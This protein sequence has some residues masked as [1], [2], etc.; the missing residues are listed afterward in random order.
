MHPCS[1]TLGLVAQA[2]FG[3]L[4]FL[5][6]FFPLRVPDGRVATLAD[7]PSQVGDVQLPVEEEAHG[8]VVGRLVL[9]VVDA[10]RWD[11]VA[12][13]AGATSMPYV[14]S[15]LGRGDSCLLQARAD[16][17]TVTMPRIKALTTGSVPGFVDVVLNLG[18]PEVG[19]DSLVG[20]AVAH[21]LKV[22]FYGDDT[23]LK[24]F[25]RG[26]ARSEGTSSFFVSDYTEVDDNVT[27]HLAAEL[28]APDWDLMV[29]HYLGLDHIGHLEGP[30][31]PLVAP[32]LREM[33]AVARQ[34]HSRLRQW[35]ESTNR[36]A[37]VVICGDHG[38]KDS[39]SHGG[40]S[41]AE[42][43][44][45]IVTLG[46]GC[47]GSR[48]AEPVGQIDLAPTLSV[49]LGLPIPAGSL[50]KLVPGLLRGLP[51]SRQLHALLYNARGLAAK[52]RGHVAAH[53]THEGWMAF[54]D[55][56]R[57]HSEWLAAGGRSDGALF[58]RAL[59]LYSI[60]AEEMSAVLAGSLV[61]FDE[62]ALAVASALLAQVCLLLLFAGP[63]PC[64]GRGE[65]LLSALLLAGNALLCAA[66][67]CRSVL[68]AAASSLPGALVAG[69][70]FFLLACNSVRLLRHSR[71]RMELPRGAAPRF[72]AAGTA[73]HTASLAATSFV[74]EEHQTWYLLW[75]TLVLLASPRAPLAA[76]LAALA[77][78]RALR[79]LN[80]TGDKWSALPDLHDWLSLPGRE[81]YLL[82]VFV[83]GLLGLLCC[84]WFLMP[85]KDTRALSFVAVLSVFCYRAAV[86]NISISF[87]PQSRGVVEA[88]VFWGALCALLASGAYRG[89]AGAGHL[90]GCWAL[91]SA[92]LHRP[93]N[94]VLVPALV[95]FSSHAH[96][97][98]WRDPPRWASVAHV[99]LGQLFYFYQGNS[100]SFASIDVAAGYVGLQDYHPYL[101]GALLV[102]HT[103]SAPVL[104]YLLLLSGLDRR[105][106][107]SDLTREGGAA[108]GEA[109]RAVA[110]ARVLPLAV[111]AA[112]T[113]WQRHHL[114]VWTVFSP[115]LLYEAV[116]TAVTAVLLLL[117]AACFQVK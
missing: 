41:P 43:L 51:P 5:C 12:G 86:G 77:S 93:H 80:Q 35:G 29:L 76:S 3:I 19:E 46:L 57:L 88:R 72:L 103:Y 9:M 54:E 87:Y 83:A 37:A 109:C 75:P 18:S 7:W 91:A 2:V 102:S 4:L 110:C 6:G 89:R 8:R 111:Y 96:H 112:L 95:L 17:P 61:E 90:A 115:K 13:P 67:R 15:Q 107:A 60:A 49:L 69:A 42:V 11:F 117:T 47:P 40:A 16:P 101:V 81:R 64:P 116:H 45:P 55:A 14:S 30:A 39:G 114:F 73:L 56:V 22:V 48:T 99:W 58:R 71:F 100:N 23:W 98:L 1:Q 78:H 44:V 31:S 84:C 59:G 65:C 97:A 82:A 68:C 108:W 33:D 94:A 85:S 53:S 66:G 24:L 113:T 27:R 70:A 62:C 63:V 26:F 28:G 105:H 38:M 36:T 79:A 34:I 52:F 74:E 106:H 104:S 25:P 10:L 32:K 50:G 92:L 21:G 20:Q